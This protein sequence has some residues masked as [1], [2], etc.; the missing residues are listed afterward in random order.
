MQAATEMSIDL[1]WAEPQIQSLTP[2]RR[3]GGRVGE[4]GRETL[5]SLVCCGVLYLFS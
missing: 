1:S 2:E 5:V 3:G 4:R